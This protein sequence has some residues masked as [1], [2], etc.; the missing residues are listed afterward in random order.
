LT[1]SYRSTATFAA[2]VEV[3]SRV[4]ERRW[5]AGGDNNVAF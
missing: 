4:E 1:D 2:V 3:Y 5:G